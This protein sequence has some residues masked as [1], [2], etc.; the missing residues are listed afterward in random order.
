[1]ELSFGTSLEQKVTISKKQIESLHILAMDMCELKD[2]LEKEQL[3]NPLLELADSHASNEY[4]PQ[5]NYWRNEDLK[6]FETIEEG[7]LSQLNLKEYS[8]KEI[9]ILYYIIH[10]LDKNGFFTMPIDELADELNVSTNMIRHSLNLLQSLEPCGICAQNL[11]QC[12]I[13]Q[14]KHLGYM[15][16][17][18]FHI[19]YEHLEDI[20][21]GKISTISRKFNLP[22]AKV[23]HYIHIIQKL[24]PR[25]LNG[26]FGEK[27]Q[28]IIPDIILTNKEGVWSTMLNDK[29]IGTIGINDYYMDMI[30]QTKDPELQEYFKRKFKRLQF[31]QHCVENRKT[32]L[33]AIC[34]WILKR[35]KDFFLGH[36]DKRPMTLSDLADELDLHISTI[37]RAMKNK[38][39][40]YPSGT[41][42]LRSLFQSGGISSHSSDNSKIQDAKSV[43]LEIINEENKKKPFSD[44]KLELLLKRKGFEIS[45]RTVA[46]Y[47]KELNIPGIYI[48]KID[49]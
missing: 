45:R 43:L 34:S 26:M 14:A 19:I 42:K 9:T 41:C 16:K 5:Q 37:S 25:P 29:W 4:F 48:R 1:M 10:N 23:R 6:T 28:Y 44:A 39:I 36:G 32:T 2:F 22:T 27:T 11:S 8:K 13:I 20:A 49:S 17:I 35:Q 33:L 15:D 7:L 24:N 46:K 21:S 12:L 30:H 38:Y 40:Q 3:E 18:L 47:R 31:I